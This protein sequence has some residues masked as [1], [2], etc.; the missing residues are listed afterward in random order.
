MNTKQ[1]ERFWSRVA[2]KDENEC[3][4]WIGRKSKKGYGIMS[5]GDYEKSA[6]RLS[7]VLANEEIPDNLCVCHSC[8]NR[9]C[10]NPAHLFLGTNKDNVIDKLKK[11]RHRTFKGSQH[12]NARLSDEQV[13]EIRAIYASKDHPPQWKLGEMYGVSQ[14]Q[15][16]L[17][18]CYKEWKHLNASDVECIDAL[19][20]ILKTRF[21]S[22]CAEIN[23]LEVYKVDF[24][25]LANWICKI[26]NDKSWLYAIIDD[27]KDNL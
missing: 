16:H 20:D 8:D 7:Y 24:S 22:E 3:W 25:A 9:A 19:V 4:E 27:A 5:V 11:G 2:I 23:N 12:F 13:L 14:S 15:I 6:H 1:I 18:V 21:V 17:I 26:V 10:V